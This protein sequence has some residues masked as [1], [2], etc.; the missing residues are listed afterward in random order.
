MSTVILTISN[1]ITNNYNNSYISS[2]T[3]SDNFGN[4]FDF[5]KIVES[6]L[7]T[8][9]CQYS[10]DVYISSLSK[11]FS[12]NYYTISDFNNIRFGFQLDIPSIENNNYKYFLYSGDLESCDTI[13]SESANPET[14][15]CLLNYCENNDYLI[16]FTN[17]YVINNVNEINSWHISSIQ[18]TSSSDT[19]KYTYNSTNETATL[20][21]NSNTN[22]INYQNIGMIG[23]IGGIIQYAN[24]DTD[25]YVQI[26]TVICTALTYYSLYMLSNGFANYTDS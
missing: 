26:D 19:Y 7:F 1:I 5:S 22:E 21:F 12:N 17:K 14:T 10:F 24:I 23:C 9:G 11:N 15:F 6:S 4:N 25:T 2:C 16:P 3:L 18:D 20:I 13:Y 8:N